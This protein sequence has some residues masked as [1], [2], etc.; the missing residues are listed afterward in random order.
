MAH[1]TEI[2]FKN[3]LTE[4][5]YHSLLKD[6]DLTQKDIKKQ[7]NIYF[8]TPDGQLRQQKKG[9]RIRLLPNQVELTLKVPQKDDYTYLEITDYLTTFQKE[10]PLIKQVF[11]SKSNVL[12][13]LKQN[14]FPVDLLEEIGSL[15]TY[16]AELQLTP[17]HLLVL[18]E[19]HY[20]GIKDFEL[21]MEVLETQ[22]GSLF[23]TQFL[24]QHNLPVRPAKKKVARMFEQMQQKKA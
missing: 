6:Y 24:S 22:E 10:L 9:L 5:E 7:T 15:T 3:L 8:D 20:G 4:T 16:R 23:F 2:E 17:A 11:T 13:Y 18:D 19:S 1:F 21:E 14:H 12:D